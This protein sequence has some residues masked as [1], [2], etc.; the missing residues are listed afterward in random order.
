MLCTSL[1]IVIIGNTSLNVALPTLARDLDATTTQLQWMVD[2]YSLVF[3]GLLFTAGALGDRYG[4]KGALQLGLVIFLGGSLLAALLGTSEGVIIGRAVMGFGAAFVMPSTLSVLANVFP[5]DER[6]QAI[7]I[8]AGVVGRRRRPRPDRQRLPPRAL[9]LG[10]GVLRQRPRSSSCALIAG[11]SSSPSRA[12]PSR[13]GSTRSVPL[14]SIVGLV[15]LVYA[16]IEAPR[17]GW[18]SPTTLAWFAAA[19]IFIGGFV[20]WELRSRHPM[21]DLHWFKNRALQRGVVRHHAG[22]LRHV[23]D[24]LP[25]SPSTSSWCSATA[26]SK[27]G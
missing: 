7:A 11:A 24:V 26:R 3:A 10:L 18:G 4:R 20:A 22:L 9:L 16:I 5:R 13:P 8:W 15:S 23:R 27:P 2:A 1:M 6:T 14:L 12:T 25:A 19:A 21:L 17:N